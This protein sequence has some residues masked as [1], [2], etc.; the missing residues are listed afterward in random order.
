MKLNNFG[1]T[2][3]WIVLFFSTLGAYLRELFFKSDFGISISVC[4][5]S[6]VVASHFLQIDISFMTV[7]STW[8]RRK[9]TYSA[10]KASNMHVIELRG[11]KFIFLAQRSVLSRSIKST[12]ETFS[13]P[14][15]FLKVTFL[16]LWNGIINYQTGRRLTLVNITRCVLDI[17]DTSSARSKAQIWQLFRVVD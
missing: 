15:H 6:R 9:I 4:I 1:R 11:K 12:Q 10:Q 17:I 16:A 14:A 2:V 8:E 3:L 7:C 13:P 5:E